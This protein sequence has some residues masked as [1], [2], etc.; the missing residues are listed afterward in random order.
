MPSDATTISPP[1][2]ERAPTPTKLAHVVLQTAQSDTMVEWY[3]TV[4]NAR[5]VFRNGL[6]SF[7][8]YD[9]E[10]HRVAFVQKG[11][12]TA[13]DP[14]ASGLAH[15][16]FTYDSLHDLLATYERLAGVGIE[17]FWCV[18]HG[19]TTSIYF[20]DPDGNQ[21]ELQVDNFD[22]LNE[23][24]AWFHSPAFA[25]N[26]IGLGFDPKDLAARLRAGTP[27]SELLRRPDV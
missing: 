17:P 6:L 11:D 18:N 20:H 12:A 23:A 25:A 7:V 10:H 27:V 22:D 2:G 14:S 9:D 21:V 16:A 4:L 19:P 24:E 15:I 8:S 1:H 13:R 26:P 3:R 5:L